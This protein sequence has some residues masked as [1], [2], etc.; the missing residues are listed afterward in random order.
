M[1]EWGTIK[2]SP[3]QIKPFKLWSIEIFAKYYS[4]P[5]LISSR[6]KKVPM[7]KNYD[8]SAGQHGSVVKPMNQEVTA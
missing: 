8:E 1:I 4:N 3:K 6:A 5:T 7:D 2:R